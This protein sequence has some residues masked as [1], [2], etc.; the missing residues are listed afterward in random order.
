MVR[1]IDK[2]RV[3][4]AHAGMSCLVAETGRKD[5]MILQSPRWE[6]A[7]KLHNKCELPEAKRQ[8]ECSRLKVSH[9]K[10]KKCSQKL[11]KD[12]WCVLFL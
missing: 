11:V 2:E 4:A 1:E 5:Q 6:I 12:T 8:M 9:L 3:M 10:K 7:S